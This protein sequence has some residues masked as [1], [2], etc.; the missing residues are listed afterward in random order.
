[1]NGC[2]APPHYAPGSTC[3]S[4]GT[5]SDRPPSL[6]PSLLARPPCM[7]APCFPPSHPL[8]GPS[9]SSGSIF[10]A[11]AC[12]LFVWVCW[13]LNQFT[14]CTMDHF[15]ADWDVQ[16]CLNSRFSK[17]FHTLGHHRSIPFNLKRQEQDRTQIKRKWTREKRK[18]RGS[19]D[20]KSLSLLTIII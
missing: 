19:I 17:Y 14:N 4:Y 9:S 6:L 7:L 16:G 12:C 15:H 13:W 1:M 10:V 8:A 20:E 5:P 2:P 11:G 3:G 18:G